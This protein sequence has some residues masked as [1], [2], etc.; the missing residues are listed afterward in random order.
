VCVETQKLIVFS[1]GGL[2]KYEIAMAHGCADDQM[3]EC[4]PA[5]ADDWIQR[6]NGDTG[7]KGCGAGILKSTKSVRI[8]RFSIKLIRF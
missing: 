2:E 4:S 3:L 5:K 7:E 6:C 1:G 8:S